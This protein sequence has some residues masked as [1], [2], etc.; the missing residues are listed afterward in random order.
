MNTSNTFYKI[1]QRIL[2]FYTVTRVLISLIFCL[3][4][5]SYDTY[6][7]VVNWCTVYLGLVC[8]FLRGSMVY[9]EYND[10]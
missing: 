6:C 1:R 5:L 8:R 4:N 3:D 2:F 10:Y 9:I 7:R